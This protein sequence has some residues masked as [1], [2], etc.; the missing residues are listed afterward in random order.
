LLI[1]PATNLEPVLLTLLVVQ[2]FGA[3]AVGR[4]TSLPLAYA[5]GLLIG[6]LTSIIPKW[7]T[8]TPS[9][10]GLP[11]AVPFLV[12]IAAL[13][14]TPRRKL[15]EVGRT[16]TVSLRTPISIGKGGN[17]AVGAAALVGA[18]AI[19]HLTGAKL[20]IWSAALA[21]VILFLSLGLLVRLSGQVSLCHIGFQAVGAATF[22]HLTDL[23]WL[24]AVLLAAAAAVPFG[25]L[26]AIPAMR[27]PTLFLATTTLGLGICFQ[28]LFYDRE[29]LF[30]G[31]NGRVAPRPDAF[32][33]D[34]D[35]GYYYLLLIFVVAT[36]A[37]VLAVENSRL[38]RLL[39]GMSDSPVAMTT[40]G[41]GVNVLRV[42]VFCLSAFLAGLSGALTGPLV[43]VVDQTRFNFL[44]SLIILTVLVI[45]GRRSIA[46][47]V[48]AALLLVVLP[49][50]AQSQWVLEYQ[51]VLFGL[52]ALLL[53][54]A[55]A[56]SIPVPGR[57]RRDPESA[58]RALA[59]RLDTPI[60]EPHRSPEL[61]R[62]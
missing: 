40:L 43:G 15:R 28:Y 11:L 5:G 54:M 9:L 61:E 51:P 25:L 21:S 22:T 62:V 1:A 55:P 42:L 6:I 14:L 19:P 12:L 27:L 29:W 35:K 10:Q 45:A 58:R 50:Y 31:S 57:P 18:I 37:L 41:T 32:G 60:R 13:F 30:G 26:A 47:P 44:N 33:F 59:A 17:R 39:R 56:V 4:F 2:A 3:A 24:V 36:A 34:G 23:P 52:G 16:A 48:I 49:G 20:G 46:T 38:G 7:T 8:N 53:A